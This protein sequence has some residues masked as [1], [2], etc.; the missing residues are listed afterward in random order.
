MLLETVSS[1]LDGFTGL[2]VSNNA[3]LRAHVIDE[4]KLDQTFMYLMMLFSEVILE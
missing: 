4:L 2:R 1:C 3:S